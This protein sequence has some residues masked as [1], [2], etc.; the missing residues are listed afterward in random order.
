MILKLLIVDIWF[1]SG[2]FFGLCGYRKATHL[3]SA[4]KYLT[5]HPETLAYG[6]EG[7]CKEIKTT[8]K[9]PYA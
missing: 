1:F 7:L 5:W 4:S 9:P 3:I 8:Q 6:A 2:F